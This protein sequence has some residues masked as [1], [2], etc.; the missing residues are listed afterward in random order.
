MEKHFLDM[1]YQNSTKLP[2]ICVESGQPTLFDGECFEL[3]SADI[4]KFPSFHIHLENNVSLT[5]HSEDYLLK[6]DVRAGGNSSLY[7]LA[8]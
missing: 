2:G 3:K 7:F 4:S 6:G 5:M 8:K 1:C